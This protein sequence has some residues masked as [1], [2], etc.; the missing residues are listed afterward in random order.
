MRD[1][2]HVARSAAQSL[3]AHGPLAPALFAL[4][5][6]MEIERQSAL[7]GR[8][9]NPSTSPMETLAPFLFLSFYHA[10]ARGCEVAGLAPR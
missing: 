3:T 6:P 10:R 9:K 1:L 4:D 8:D 7:I 2:V 5:H